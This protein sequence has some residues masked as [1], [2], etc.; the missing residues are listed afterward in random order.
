MGLIFI[1]MDESTEMCHN[2]RDA[3]KQIIFLLIDFR[4]VCA[5][6]G[7][8][9]TTIVPAWNTN[10]KLR[11]FAGTVGTRAH[12]NQKLKVG[13]DISFSGSSIDFCELLI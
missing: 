10:W 5:A 9:Q 1:I 6:F 13:D 12:S 7:G 4:K 3:N 11:R 8:Y 2:Y